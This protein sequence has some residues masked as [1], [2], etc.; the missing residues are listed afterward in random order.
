MGR[1][2]DAPYEP[3]PELRLRLLEML[4]PFL[5]GEISQSSFDDQFYWFVDEEVT[6]PPVDRPLADVC[7]WLWR[8]YGETSPD[9]I[10]VTL[11]E[12]EFLCRCTAW[13]QTDLHWNS[14]WGGAISWF[15][16]GKYPYIRL[17]DDY[18]PFDTVNLWKRH[19]HLATRFAFPDVPPPVVTL[20]KLGQ[21]DA[22]F[23]LASRDKSF[24][25]IK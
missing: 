5:K 8:R 4:V 19:A 23:K 1:Q 25:L 24:R 7:E 11:L 20:P 2:F 17:D 14:R 22:D 15:S 21:S 10:D 18:S 3:H 12:Y 6:E 13:L 9:T 16:A